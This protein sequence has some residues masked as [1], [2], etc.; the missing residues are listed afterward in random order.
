MW[1]WWFWFICHHT[2]VV[3]PVYS[4]S[5]QSGFQYITMSHW[6]WRL[7]LQHCQRKLSLFG[8]SRLQTPH[9]SHDS[10]ESMAVKDM[11]AVKQVMGILSALVSCDEGQWS[12]SDWRCPRWP[13]CRNEYLSSYEAREGKT[14]TSP[15]S[16]L[17]GWGKYG[18]SHDIPKMTPWYNEV[19]ITWT[20]NGVEAHQRDG[21]LSIS[22]SA[23]TTLWNRHL[24]YARPS[25]QISNQ[26][27]KRSPSSGMQEVCRCASQA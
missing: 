23:E 3:L 26:G 6:E 25:F 13:S 21:G 14:A 2:F 17:T 18:R 15:I 22:N 12:R 10:L 5:F 4:F 16:V 7:I 27:K 24:G 1:L 8:H 9:T 11:L 19:T 20:R